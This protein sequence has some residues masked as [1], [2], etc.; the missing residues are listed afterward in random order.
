MTT[1]R[2]VSIAL[3]ASLVLVAGMTHAEPRHRQNA[4]AHQRE[5]GDERRPLRDVIG[6]VE[7]NYR[8]RVVDVQPARPG[9]DHDMYRMRVLQEGGRVKT[10]Q[11]PAERQRHR[12]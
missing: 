1:L 4:H 6:E 8:G 5:R 7:H 3:L 10:V 11:V 9:G 2:L 12:D